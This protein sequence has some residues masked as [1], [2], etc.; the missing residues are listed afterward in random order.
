MTGYNLVYKSGKF[1]ICSHKLHW[2]S[3]EILNQY[4]A[5]FYLLEC[6]FHAT[7]KH[8]DTILKVESFWIF[9]TFLACRLHST[10]AWWRLK[11]NSYSNAKRFFIA[12][13]HA[14]FRFWS[15]ERLSDRS[16]SKRYAKSDG[17]PWVEKSSTSRAFHA[18]NTWFY[19]LSAKALHERFIA[20][21]WRL[22]LNENATTHR[23]ALKNTSVRVWIQFNTPQCGSS[24]KSTKLRTLHFDW[25]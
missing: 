18:H 9:L 24:E 17:A 11:L 15:H 5:F 19:W 22:S 8:Y 7:S 12:F 23:S 25:E 14:H 20:Q 10:S 1:I 6:I 2:L 3:Q 13:S 16:I 4:W 21:Q